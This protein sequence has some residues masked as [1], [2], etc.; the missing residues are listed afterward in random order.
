LQPILDLF[1]AT[2]GIAKSFKFAPPGYSQG[3]FRFDSDVLSISYRT[4]A[5]GADFIAT[6]S[7][8]VIQVLDE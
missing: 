1:T 7:L 8:A 5:R 3:D 2:R 6:L 4:S